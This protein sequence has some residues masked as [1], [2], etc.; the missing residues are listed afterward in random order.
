MNLSECKQ[1]L[2]KKAI[3]SAKASPA[4][5]VAKY[6]P[7]A[8][9][10]SVREMANKYPTH[11]DFSTA[12]NANRLKHTGWTVNDL[13]E[14]PTTYLGKKLRPAIDEIAASSG[15]GFTAPAI[16]RIFLGKG[17]TPAQR[18]FI[19]LHE[20]FEADNSTARN[21]NLIF[22]RTPQA[23]EALIN[24]NKASWF[25]PL[26]KL[27]AARSY[28]K[29]LPN[30]AARHFSPEVLLSESEAVR[31]GQVNP[32]MYGFRPESEIQA[33]K[34]GWGVDYGKTPLPEGGAAWNRAL[35]RAKTTI[36]PGTEKNPVYDLGPSFGKYVSGIRKYNLPRSSFGSVSDWSPRLSAS[37]WQASTYRQRP[38]S[39]EAPFMLPV[40]PYSTKIA[41]YLL[42]QALSPLAVA[43]LETANDVTIGD[44]VA[45]R[46]GLL[47]MNSVGVVADHFNFGRNDVLKRA[48][49]L[50]FVAGAFAGS[51]AAGVP[52][53]M[54]TADPDD[55]N[56]IQTAMKRSIE[57]ASM[58]RLVGT[59]G[60]LGASW[61]DNLV[62]KKGMR[63]ASYKL[64]QI[65]LQLLASYMKV[66]ERPE[67]KKGRK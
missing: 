34:T 8:T 20:G 41:S 40:N 64:G 62:N 22:S 1:Y 31:T 47:G 30:I 58:P 15:G 56:K 2:F 19:S 63:P 44:E 66:K 4:E 18:E 16:K 9:E 67:F 55:P 61:L 57:E 59:L 49:G 27:F 46:L 29:Q 6:N 25:N 17:L 12:L 24:Y 60:G 21:S 52:I 26:N 50:G 36:V 23:P 65:P 43:A 42:K 35:D 11:E 38:S 39:P 45:K 3:L 7:E 54:M 48:P 28:A 53:R 51:N 37:N 33:M 32:S 14:E 13:R 10:A 5:L